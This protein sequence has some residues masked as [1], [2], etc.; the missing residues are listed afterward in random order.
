VEQQIRNLKLG[1]KNWL[2]AASE[3]GAETVAVMNSLVCTCRMNNINFLDYITDVLSNL[4]SDSPQSL[5]PIEWAE[6]QA[7]KILPDQ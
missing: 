3:A 4:D 6:E 2:F 5:T 1:A 7:V